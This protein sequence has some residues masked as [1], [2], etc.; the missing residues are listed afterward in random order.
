MYSVLRGRQNA[1]QRAHTEEVVDDVL[2]LYHSLCA[3]VSVRYRANYLYAY[4]PSCSYFM[5]LASPHKQ[6]LESTATTNEFSQISSFFFCILLLI[7]FFYK[8][9]A[10]AATQY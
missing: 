1:V 6:Y 7:F 4:L 5:A 2:S 3:C 9:A 8:Y 10:H